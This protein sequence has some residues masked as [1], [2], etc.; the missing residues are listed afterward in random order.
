MRKI[1]AVIVFSVAIS[2]MLGVVA[3][4][5]TPSHMDRSKVPEGCAGCHSGTGVSGT[6]LLKK[7]MEEM[8]FYC[9]GALNRERSRIDIES[10]FAKSSRH[11]IFE[12]AI[13]HSPGEQLPEKLASA[14][15]HVSCYDCHVVHR[16]TPEKPWKGARGYAPGQ[17]R[18]ERGG[19]PLG[20][21]LREATEE[22]ELCYLCHS[23]SA[24]LPS[25]TENIS[26][27]FNPANESYHPVEMTGKNK[28]VPSLVR[29]LD[30]NSVITCSSCHGND[31]RT[32][33]RG[34]HGSDYEPILIAEYRTQDGPEDDKA[35]ELCY[36][37]H[38]RRS[39]LG[40]ESFK[41]HNLHI[42]FFETSCYT[43]HT[44][45]GSR[46]NKHLIEFNTE[47]VSESDNGDLL[48]LPGAPGTP[49]CSLKCHGVNHDA[50]DDAAGIGG[51][52]WPW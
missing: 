40:D 44:T 27:Q 26:E 35:Y 52:P 37:C 1:I 45:H 13:Y 15:R 24:N 34:P 4:E 12:T 32:G 36:I 38:D 23:D 21:R 43:C 8:C 33:P 25:D 47:V 50:D 14:P 31:D 18:Q 29:D 5:G 2:V 46:D 22:Y 28:D 51:K 41:R 16:S 42:V 6:P 19:V 11:P 48:Y 3:V 30:V 7:P 49:R 39:I 20:L 9:H 10:V 17:I